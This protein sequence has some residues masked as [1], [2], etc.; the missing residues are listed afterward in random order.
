MR[1]SV[2]ALSL[3]LLGGSCGWSSEIG[4]YQLVTKPDGLTYKIDTSTGQVWIYEIMHSAFE[5]V[6]T[7]QP[8]KTET[9]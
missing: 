9:P 4:R 7:I 2:L 3:T 5:P 6:Q 8:S 1:L